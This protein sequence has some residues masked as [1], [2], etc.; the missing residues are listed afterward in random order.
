MQTADNGAQ[1]HPRVVG[2]FPSWWPN[3]SAFGDLHHG[4]AA[5]CDHLLPSMTHWWLVLPW[6]TVLRS[7]SWLTLQPSKASGNP[8][9]AFFGGLN[10]WRPQECNL[11]TLILGPCL[12]SNPF[13]CVGSSHSNP[14]K[15]RQKTSSTF[16]ITKGCRSL[17][18]GKQRLFSFEAQ[19]PYL[20]GWGK[21]C[22][23]SSLLYCFVE[24]HFTHLYSKMSVPAPVSLE[25]SH[26]LRETLSPLAPPPPALASCLILNIHYSVSIEYP[27]VN[28]HTPGL[29]EHVVFPGWLNSLTSV[30]S[31]Q[32]TL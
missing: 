4:R 14:R 31:G 6:K 1:R 17:R 8:H 26:A 30:F 29:T 20:L 22:S 25:H 16:S 28:F 18:D 11:L 2:R 32:L 27:H 7:E 13:P 9:D 10:T 15:A 12:N 5:G 19:N 24:I 21:R 3:D 23:M